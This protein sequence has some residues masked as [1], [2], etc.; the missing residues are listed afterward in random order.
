MDCYDIKAL[1]ERLGDIK[2]DM[3]ALKDQIETEQRSFT[4]DEFSK[5]DELETEYNETKTKVE[6]AERLARVSNDNKKSDVV[7]AERSY[8]GKP[9]Q[10][11]ITR[12]DVGKATK[13]WLTRNTSQFKDEYANAAEKCNFAWNSPSLNI[14]LLG[15]NETIQER[16]QSV[17]TANKGG[18]T[19]SDE[20]VGGFEEA[21]KSYWNWAQYCTIHR[22]SHNGPHRIV[23]VNNTAT[24]AAY[25][26]ELA[27]IDNADL[28]FGEA[29][30]N[31]Y[32]LT[33]GVFPVS[34]ELL[35]DNEIGLGSYIGKALGERIART[36]ADEITTGAG[37]GSSNL[38]GFDAA[39]TQGVET[40]SGTAIDQ[41]ELIDLY[42]SVND[43][44]RSNAIWMMHSLVLAALVKLEDSQGRKLFGPGLNGSPQ[45]TLLGK[46]VVVNDYLPSALSAG[47][48]VIYFGDFSHV[49]VRI[50]RDVSIRESSEKY[51]LE[52]AKAFIATLRADSKYVNA[53]TDPIKHLMMNDGV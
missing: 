26:A 32:K 27:A 3:I 17:G 8:S 28:T 21:L 18:H 49:H 23:T 50:V 47:N 41:D 29:V 15:N 43:A 25:E 22:T 48:K 40:T 19:V 38:T 11:V 5:W 13:A 33:S 7:V 24:A 4:D 12:S 42:F 46:P 34:N 20:I 16:S 37:S 31:S 39:T 14:N 6:T 52:D 10:E 44:Y 36:L 1:K 35:E 51:F 30:F 53:G 45:S 2:E 9:K